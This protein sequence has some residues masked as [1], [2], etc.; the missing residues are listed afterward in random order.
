MN[1]RLPRSPRGPRFRRAADIHR[2]WPRP[3]SLP[4]AATHRGEGGGT[5]PTSPIYCGVGGV[6]VSY[7]LLAGTRRGKLAVG[8]GALLLWSS[9]VRLASPVRAMKGWDAYEGPPL[10]CR[11]CSSARRIG[12]GEG[13][14]L[15]S[16]VQRGK[17]VLRPTI[18]IE[19]F[20]VQNADSEYTPA[21]RRGI[22]ARLIAH[23][24]HVKE[25]QTGESSY[26]G[27]S[28]SLSSS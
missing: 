19:S 11:P 13:D 5:V 3:K 15:E 22:D 20:Q 27:P 6:L 14:R 26:A 28:P 12:V 7:G 25:Q 18:V 24:A 21:Q 8:A 1:W 4:F 9:V 23:I 17:I 10:W 16:S 2:G